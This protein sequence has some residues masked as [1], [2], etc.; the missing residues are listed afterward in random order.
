MKKIIVIV[1][2]LCSAAG[3]G[4][5]W[6]TARDATKDKAAPVPTGKIER[7]P[8]RQAV[9]SSGKVVSNLD[10]EIKCKAS[11][12]VIRLPFDVSQEVKKGD[13][14][15]ELDPR[16]EQQRVRQAEATVR[17]SQA[18]LVNARESLA[19]AQ[20]TLKTDRQRAES[21]L[22]AAQAQARDARAKADRTRELQAKKLASLEETE[23]AETA[24]AQAA[25][26]A[27]SAAARIEELRSQARTLEQARQQIRIAEAQVDTD[28]VS[29]DLARQRLTETRVVS[30]LDGV[31]TQ[32]AVQ[33][34]QI[35]SSGISNVG[36]GTTA[37]VVSDLSRIFVLAAVDESDIGLVRPGQR[38]KVTV[39][40]FRS[41]EFAGEVQRI[42]PRGVNVSNVVT[43]E[44]KVEVTAPDKGLLRPEMTANVEILIDERADALLAPADALFRRSGRTW[45]TVV[46]PDGTRTDREVAT[47]IGDG[48]RTEVLS[49][50]AEGDAVLLVQSAE[51][52]WN[53]QGQRPP[54]AAMPMMRPR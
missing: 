15:L 45:A 38:V 10:V 4:Y 49:G 39:D 2:L 28:Q 20:E 40:A 47:G 1:V 3:G 30:P 5:W 26:V 42:S 52:R 33:I 51:S 31:V 6:W 48:R 43:F 37:L 12:E 19:L 29:L 54:S 8:V 21:A 16:D 14:L 50:L 53:G 17:A 18:K 24:A 35:I 46:A 13:L 9:S 7:G 23:T 34:G 36:G 41:R 22:T 32:R 27:E 25:A 44:V 11:G